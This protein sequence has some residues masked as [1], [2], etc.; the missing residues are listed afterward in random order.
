MWFD[1]NG[2]ASAL[3]PDQEQFVL[4]SR[5]RRQDG[6]LGSPGF[7]GT[8]DHP[9]PTTPPSLLTTCQA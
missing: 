1:V 2:G 3:S 4:P 5:R 9:G 8:P 6:L 7:R